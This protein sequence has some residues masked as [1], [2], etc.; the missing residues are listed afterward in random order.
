MLLMIQGS[1]VA[2]ILLHVCLTTLPAKNFGR[3]FFDYFGSLISETFY[4]ISDNF[5]TEISGKNFGHFAEMFVPTKTRIR[6]RNIYE[7]CSFTVPS[8]FYRLNDEPILSS[9]L[10]GLEFAP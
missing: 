10:H 7:N 3:F 5:R 4:L 6:C 8:R 9:S 1:C 2:L